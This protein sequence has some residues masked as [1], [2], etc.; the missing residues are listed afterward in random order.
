MSAVADTPRPPVARMDHTNP[1]AVHQR[2]ADIEHELALKQGPLE[3]AADD[4]ARLTRDWERRLALQTKVAHGP[5]V[6]VRKA[7]ALTASILQDYHE[8][9]DGAGDGTSLY[10]RLTDAE[11]RYD[12]LRLVVRVLGDRAT[13]GMS[14]K[15]TQERT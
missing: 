2:L 6:D 12:S 14:I 4:R 13:I 7:N 1:A 8:G 10:E 9:P 11:A 15:K 3:Q 5:S